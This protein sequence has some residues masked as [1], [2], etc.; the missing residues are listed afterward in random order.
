MVASPAYSLALYSTFAE[1]TNRV[2]QVE[3]GS[4]G[5]FHD[6]GEDVCQYSVCLA[7]SRG[8]LPDAESCLHLLIG[9]FEA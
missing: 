1:G 6:L 9:H 2:I 8:S 7:G 4:A 5:L 3:G